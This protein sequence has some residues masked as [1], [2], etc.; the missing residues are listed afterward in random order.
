[1]HLTEPNRSELNLPTYLLCYL[2]TYLYIILHTFTKQT[3]RQILLTRR[4]F[5][6]GLPIRLD[7]DKLKSNPLFILPN[8]QNMT[9]TGQRLLPEN[10]EQWGHMTVNDP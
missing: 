4:K 8:H 9:K 5:T 3:P 1:V 10:A 2:L 7:N 6:Q